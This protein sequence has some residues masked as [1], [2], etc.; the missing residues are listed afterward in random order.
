MV[1]LSSIKFVSFSKVVFTLYHHGSK[2]H[3][4]ASARLLFW[5]ICIK[6]TPKTFPHSQFQ[7]AAIKE[8]KV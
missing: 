8:F 6:Q 2:L 4:V 3:V 7:S 1:Q 5:E